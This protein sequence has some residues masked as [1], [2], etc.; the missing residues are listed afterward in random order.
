MN[1]ADWFTAV[2]SPITF[3]LVL[4]AEL[5]FRRRFAA[6]S[7][8]VH[9]DPPDDADQPRY[10]HYTLINL[11]S[12][13]A[14]NVSI[15]STSGLQSTGSRMSV[16]RSGDNFPTLNIQDNDFDNDWL[17]VTWQSTSDYRY[18]NLMWFP[19]NQDGHL[20]EVHQSQWAYSNRRRRWI[21][22]RPKTK[23]V[24]PG[25]GVLRTVVKVKQPH[26]KM[27]KDVEFAR[28]LLDATR[29]QRFAK[30]RQNN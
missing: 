27:V 19:L 18:V 24:G 25:G 17:L 16:V 5:R 11:G 21:R 13:T 26:D 14:T 28:S 1:V 22:L 7:W 23:R 15:E 6:V 10:H 30:L 12:D 8:W 2:L 9:Y 3:G 29:E 4:V 20:D